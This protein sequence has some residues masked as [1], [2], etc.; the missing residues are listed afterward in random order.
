MPLKSVIQKG[1]ITSKS[2]LITLLIEIFSVVLVLL[3]A[4]PFESFG[5]YALNYDYDYLNP[6]TIDE[7]STSLENK[8]MSNNIYEGFL[9]PRALTTTECGKHFF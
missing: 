8:M 1:N 2:M 4:L 6:E 9:N 7:K 3:I 5:Q